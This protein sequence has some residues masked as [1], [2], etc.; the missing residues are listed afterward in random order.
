MYISRGANAA[1]TRVRSDGLIIPPVCAKE[2]M[3][4]RKRVLCMDLWCICWF[5]VA[6]LGGQGTVGLAK[7]GDGSQLEPNR[8]ENMVTT[9]FLNLNSGFR[10]RS[11]QARD[12]IATGLRSTSSRYRSPSSYN[13]V[14][15]LL[16][17][18]RYP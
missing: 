18:W 4:A 16:Y 6:V 14:N 7:P 8:C 3:L 1:F 13:R 9:Y 11:D 5:I 10:N 12:S 2:C 17:H 15:C